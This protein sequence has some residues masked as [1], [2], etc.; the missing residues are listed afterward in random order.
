MEGLIYGATMTDET[1]RLVPPTEDLLGFCTECFRMRWLAVLDNEA[2]LPAGT[3]R[4]CAR[5]AEE[6]K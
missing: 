2:P 4:Q 5:E 6:G 3:C 1:T